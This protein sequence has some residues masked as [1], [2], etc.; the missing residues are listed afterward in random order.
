MLAILAITFPFFALVLC[1]YVAVRRHMLPQLAIPGLNSF[2]L[3]FALPCLLYRFG[4]TTPLAQLLDVG[5]FG[6]YLLC[7]LAT[8]GITM[9]LTLRR[10]GW[11]NAAFGALVAAFPNT[12]FMGVPLLVA[13]LGPRASGPV[14]VTV[15]VD[16]IITSSLCIALSRLG[17]TGAAG[18]GQSSGAALRNAMAGMVRNPMPWSIL[19]GA[20][21]SGIGLVLPK[22]LMQTVGLLADAA[23]P[24]ALFTIGAVLARS[25]MNAAEPTPLSAFVPVA[26]IKLLIHPLFMLGIGHAAIRLG[27]PLDSFT[28]TVLV[29]VACLPSASNVAMLTERFGADTARVARIILVST[30]L[31]FLT[32]S[33]AVA[34]LRSA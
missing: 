22:P 4:S 21:A 13:L 2:V 34:L 3:Y 30:A 29:L 12:G 17:G 33:G 18:S 7:A 1:G 31:S 6:V 14:I 19:L 5:V 28:L 27:V 9:L 15:V 20:L 16:M 24:V 26:L 8:V 11:N 25:H 23:S 32:F 10:A